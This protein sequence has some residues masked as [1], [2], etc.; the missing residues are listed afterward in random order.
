MGLNTQHLTDIPIW[1]ETLIIGLFFLVSQYTYL[2][3]YQ[4]INSKQGPY[5]RIKQFLIT[6]GKNYVICICYPIKWPWTTLRTYLS[7]NFPVCE[8]QDWDSM[9]VASPNNLVIL[10]WLH[11]MGLLAI[12]F[13]Q[14]CHPQKTLPLQLACYSS[15][16]GQMKRERIKAAI[17]F[18][19][20]SYQSFLYI[21]AAWE[22][23]GQGIYMEDKLIVLNKLTLDCE[24]NGVSSDS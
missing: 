5:F 23:I 24:L 16:F 18:K 10:W 1:V 15:F 11:V 3:S 7:I 6:E 8:T 19:G 4:L 17:T 14:I 2:F 21:A 9:M 22:A 20:K 12:Y 13:L